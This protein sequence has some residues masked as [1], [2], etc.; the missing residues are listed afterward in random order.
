MRALVAIGRFEVTV[1]AR[2][3]PKDDIA[4]VRVVV[5]DFANHEA[6]TAALEGHDA[7]VSSLSRAAIPSQASLIDAAIAAGVQRFIPSE[8]GANLQN[9]N[10]RQLAAY[11]NKVRVEEYLERKAAET[12]I[13]YTYVYIN[14]LLDWSMKAGVLLDRTRQIVPLYDGGTNRVSMSTIPSTAQAVVGVLANPSETSN[15]AVHVHATIISQ[16]ELLGYVKELD[17]NGS[18]SGQVIEFSELEKGTSEKDGKPGGQSISR[19]HVDAMKAAFAKNYGNRFDEQ[20]NKLLE[21]P[22][23]SEDDVKSLLRSLM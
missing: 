22:A 12:N 17:P 6:L 13:T 5:V 8:F 21:I 4:G 7:V 2:A 9:E 1:L 11:Q 20:D 23:M 18:W 19:F 14:S 3:R 15:R 16:R 10:A